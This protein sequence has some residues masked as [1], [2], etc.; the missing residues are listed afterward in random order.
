MTLKLFD[1]KINH[2][3]VFMLSSIEKLINKINYNRDQL[4]NIQNL[5]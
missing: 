1:G 3:K 4:I 5:K 2:S